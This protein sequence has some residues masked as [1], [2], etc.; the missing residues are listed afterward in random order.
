M[1]GSDTISSVS[2]VDKLSSRGYQSV[3]YYF[4]HM[5]QWTNIF[6][7]ALVLPA[8]SRKYR[9]IASWAIIPLVLLSILPHKEP[10]YLV[11]IIPFMAVLAGIGLWQWGGKIV[12]NNRRSLPGKQLLALL[13]V[14]TVIASFLFESD[15]FRFR[16]SESAVDAARYLMKQKDRIIHCSLCTMITA[17]FITKPSIGYTIYMQR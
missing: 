3:L 17:F 7:A 10:R 1:T 9:H 2:S 8:F 15:R 14:F 6:W 11:P 16:R 5:G 12:R 4:F 13:L